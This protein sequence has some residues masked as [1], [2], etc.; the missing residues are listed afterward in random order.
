MQ[1]P[2]LL[3]HWIS[4]L[5]TQ[6]E[7][8]MTNQGPAPCP[9]ASRTATS[10]PTQP[11]GLLGGTAVTWRSNQKTAK[12]PVQKSLL[13][14]PRRRWL[15]L[16]GPDRVKADL[17]Q[18]GVA[19]LFLQLPERRLGTKHGSQFA[20]QPLLAPPSESS[21]FAG[22]RARAR[23]HLCVLERAAGRG[24]ST[25]PD[26]RRW[27]LPHVHRGP[28]RAREVLGRERKRPAGLRHGE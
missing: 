22:L 25:L 17:D 21:A 23:A 8:A 11:C 15:V 1:E 24:G 5:L 13:L 6:P 3:Q 20:L 19:F 12:L 16:P 9:Q 7:V 14:A 26:R 28:E 18:R 2:L 27:Q 4:Q 10:T